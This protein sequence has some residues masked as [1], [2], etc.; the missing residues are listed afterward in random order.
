[1]SLPVVAF[2]PNPIALSQSVTWSPTFTLSN[3]L[4][5]H[6]ASNMYTFSGQLGDSTNRLLNTRSTSLAIG[7]P[8][9]FGRWNW[10]NAISVQDQYSNQRQTVNLPDPA[11]TTRR[12]VR[13]YDQTFETDIDWS[14]G[15]GLPMLFQGSWN[16]QP[17][18][19]VVNTT[20][21]PFM[22]RNRYSGASSRR[23]SGWRTPSPS[24][25]RSTGCFPASGRSRGSATPSRPAFRGRT[26][27]P[28]RSRSPTPGPSRRADP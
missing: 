19:S 27:P 7:T 17:S 28:R 12:L 23:E 26:P 15:I 16:L 11:D 10:A 13:T 3:A 14:T 22:L 9:R 4:Q 6:A 20:G 2:T 1:M 21:G 24:R 8:I 25:R 18:I 5:N